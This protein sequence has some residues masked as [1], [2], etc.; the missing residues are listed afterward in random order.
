MKEYSMFEPAGIWEKAD[1][2]AKK[3]DDNAGIRPQRWSESAHYKSDWRKGKAHTRRYAGGCS[4]TRGEINRFTQLF[5]ERLDL[6]D[7][8]GEDGDEDKNED[9]ESGEPLN[10]SL[11]YL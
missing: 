7:D 2:W 5:R 8:E 11:A 3:V 6:L 10:F 1:A 4:T 9:E